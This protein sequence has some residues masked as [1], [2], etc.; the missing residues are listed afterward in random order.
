MK[1]NNFFYLFTIGLGMSLAGI[2]VAASFTFLLQQPV[3]AGGADNVSGW[4]WSSNIG[5]ISFNCTNP[6]AGGCAS[7]YGVNVDSGTGN[8]SGY[9]WAATNDPDSAIGW[10][11]FNE[12]GPTP[13]GFSCG[14]NCTA[15]L[16]LGT[17]KVAGWAR[18]LA[19]GG[20]WD[21]W[22]KLRDDIDGDSV[23]DYGVKWNSLAGELEGWAW[24]G[25][26]MGWIAFNKELDGV[27]VHGG[28]D[29]AVVVGGLNLPPA[30]AID[31][32]SDGDGFPDP[33][34]CVGFIG[35]LQLVNNSSD[36]DGS[37]VRSTWDVDPPNPDTTCTAPPPPSGVCDYQV[38]L[39]TPG[40][41]YNVILAVEDNDGATNTS[42]TQQFQVKQDI[43]ADFEC[44]LSGA[45]GSWVN[46]PTIKVSSGSPVY[47]RAV[48]GT[49]LSVPSQGATIV[50]WDWD[51]ALFAPAG[52]S[53]T[54]PTLSC[55]G[56]A[57]N[58][59]SNTFTSGNP[60]TFSAPGQY[61]L[62]L[63][64]A[65]DQAPTSRSDCAVK[66]LT[67]ALPFPGWQEVSPL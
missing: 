29:H 58:N 5:W 65:D 17:K 27:N 13:D 20:G 46:C 12:A 59:C 64:V 52:G 47:F 40:V 49:N 33:F 24:G 8:F 39:G 11:S 36:P 67:V 56:P 61:T 19:N 38:Q 4:A 66:T 25:E 15:K 51:F 18:A 62:Q 44:S 43:V 53:A 2:L 37:I 21:G 45:V 57:P 34:P 55:A 35:E 42:A 6:G 23:D 30:A 63:C 14:A 41:L 7:N 9:A 48:N 10:I 22:I 50:D 3:E 31:C 60:V 16:D 1:R 54:P 26:V 28:E 32:D